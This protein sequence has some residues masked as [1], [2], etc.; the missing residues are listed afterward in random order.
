MYINSHIHLNKL[1]VLKL[2]IQ[3]MG[4]MKYKCIS[5]FNKVSKKVR[6]FDSS[7]F[8]TLFFT[9]L[10]KHLSWE[11][12]KTYELQYNSY[13]TYRPMYNAYVRTRGVCSSEI[14]LQHDTNFSDPNTNTNSTLLPQQDTNTNFQVPTFNTKNKNL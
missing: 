12:N 5:D 10:L 9:S 7:L 11:V 13:R 8:S 1:L 6:Q 2:I 4:N 14:C 3:S